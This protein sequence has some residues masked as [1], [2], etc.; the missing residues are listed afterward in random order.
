MNFR[1]AILVIAALAVLY[2]PLAPAQQMYRWVDENGQVHYSDHVPPSYASQDRELLNTQGVSLQQI[3]GAASEEELAELE[4]Q[5]Q[6]EEAARRAE[7]EKSNRDRV[8]LSTYLS[9][10][11]IVR[12]RDQRI[13]LL[14]AQIAVTE[15]YLTSLNQR[16]TEI[17]QHANRFKPYSPDPDA[18]QMPRNLELDL[19]QTADSIEL[20]RA[21][22]ARSREQRQALTD[23]FARDIERFQELTGG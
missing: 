3:D 10:E 1:L 20:Y 18:P 5:E 23:A 22:L 16:L 7:I 2:L 17:R 13:E 11:E 12:L 9:V 19:E 6:E 14:D 15:Q 21:T 8:L 4:R